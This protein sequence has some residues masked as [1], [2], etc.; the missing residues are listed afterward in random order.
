MK[1]KKWKRLRKILEISL[2]AYNT[3]IQIFKLPSNTQSCVKWDEEGEQADE[4]GWKEWGCM[5]SS[6]KNIVM[7]KLGYISFL[8]MPHSVNFFPVRWI[9]L[10]RGKRKERKK[11]HKMFNNKYNVVFRDYIFSWTFHFLFYPNNVAKLE[12]NR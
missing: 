9:N 8:R 12:G 7:R 10:K 3:W 2:I 6:V 5:L 1:N 4:A 11:S